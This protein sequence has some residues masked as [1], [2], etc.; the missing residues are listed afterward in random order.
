MSEKFIPQNPDWE[1]VTRQIFAGQSFMTTLGADITGIKPGFFEITIP[2]RDGLGQQGGFF[3]GGVIGTL[4]DNAAGC[5]AGTLM[6]KN[7]DVLAVEFKVNLV[8][9]GAGDALIG[10]AQ[11]MKPGKTLCVCR[12]EVYAKRQGQEILCAIGQS[13]LIY[14]SVT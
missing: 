7:T 9:P 14:Q 1:M 2:W 5:A 11:V 13:T 8:R 10:R 6:P 12:S 3:H 4:V